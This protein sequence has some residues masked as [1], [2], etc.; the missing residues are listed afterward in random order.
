MIKLKKERQIM[1]R[2]ENG[3]IFLFSQHQSILMYKLK[4]NET[5]PTSNNMWEKWFCLA[6]R[7]STIWEHNFVLS[8]PKSFF[9]SFEC[10]TFKIGLRSVS[11]EN[12]ITIA[13]AVFSHSKCKDIVICGQTKQKGSNIHENQKRKSENI[14]KCMKEIS[15]KWKEPKWNWAASKSF[16]WLLFWP[17]R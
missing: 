7:S 15:K 16:E 10:V 5:K 8:E 11:M 6:I 17:L 9:V 12:K 1:N 13:V 2:L 14:K 3:W 4:K